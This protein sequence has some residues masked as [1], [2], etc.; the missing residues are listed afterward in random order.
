MICTLLLLP[1]PVQLHLSIL[2]VFCATTAEHYQRAETAVIIMRRPFS[3]NQSLLL[4]ALAIGISILSASTPLFRPSLAASAGNDAAL[5]AEVAKQVEQQFGLY[6]SPEANRYIQELGGRLAAVANDPRWKFT[7]QIV[8]QDEPNAF[9]IPGGGIY[10]SRGLLALV[11]R[12]DELA[13]ALA[14][15]LVH[16]MKRH[17]AH[18]Q[19]RGFLPGLLSVPGKIVGSV[20]SEDLGN[21]INAPIETVGGAW[22]SRYSRGQESES[23]RLGIAIAANAGYDPS[24]LADLLARLDAAVKAETGQERKFSMFDSHPMTDTRLSD[25][26]KRAPG[27]TVAAK[28]KVAPDSAAL[29]AKL[30]GMW[31]GENPDQGVLQKDQF[32]QPSIGFAITLPAGWKH[33]NTP[34]YLISAHPQKE[35]MLLLGIAGPESDPELT[36]QKFVAKMRTK[37]RT[38]PVSS[39]KTSVGNFPAYVVTYLDPSGRKTVY[40]HVAW[41]AMAGKTYQLIGL[42]PDKDKEILRTAALSLRPLTATER[43]TVTGRRLRA[44]PAQKGETLE[45]FNSRTKNTWSAA[46]TSLANGF[47]D[48]TLNEGQ[49]LKISRE[50]PWTPPT[51]PR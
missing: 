3:L 33:Q 10:V 48:P 43:S 2:T 18:E 45:T 35:A 32:L 49:P 29:F 1:I 12:E 40:L 11:N 7:F 46:Y 34:Q 19:K 51:L 6:T 22:L 4:G 26:R 38:E 30:D 42:A 23:D 13:G 20:V 8:D 44:V 21:L 15:E 28:S 47:S 41:V 37:A 27:L 17:S 50:E 39:R 16:V 5:G 14:H 9:A 31:L 25:I 36:G 24:A